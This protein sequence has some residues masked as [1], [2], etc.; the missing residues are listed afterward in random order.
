[1]S[2]FEFWLAVFGCH[3]SGDSDPGA[4]AAEGGWWHKGELWDNPDAKE[5]WAGWA[6]D[7]TSTTAP[8]RWC[9]PWLTAH[10]ARGHAELVTA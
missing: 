1:M 7:G 3:I 2:E 10:I 5:R 4:M 8:D 6:P 9:L